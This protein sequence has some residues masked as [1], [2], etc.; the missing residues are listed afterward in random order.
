MHLG[1]YTLHNYSH[2]DRTIIFA[3]Y[4]QALCLGHSL[5]S[6][7]IRHT[8]I[9]AYLD[10]AALLLTTSDMGILNPTRRT[11]G[12]GR[13]PLLA[14]VLHEHKRWESIPN[15]REPVTKAM[16]TWII[17]N[18]KGKPMTHITQAL[19]DWCILALF[20]G[21]RQAEFLQTTEN[22]RSHRL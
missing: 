14:K 3:C 20:F 12:L 7:Q 6:K 13:P 18:A 4:A 19:A 11:T 16:L 15:R 2:H 17:S 8:T 9:V 21:F 1:S 22:L 10:A 5:L